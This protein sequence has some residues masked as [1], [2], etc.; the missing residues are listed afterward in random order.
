MAIDRFT[1]SEAY[2]MGDVEVDNLK[3]VMDV[4]YPTALLR[5]FIIPSYSFG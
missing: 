4:S 3:A 5:I 2:M 1:V